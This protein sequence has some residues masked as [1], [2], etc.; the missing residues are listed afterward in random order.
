MPR[1]R[2][3]AWR[4]PMSAPAG[5]KPEQ[6]GRLVI[7]EAEAEECRIVCSAALLEA[8]RRECV[9]AARG[10]VPLGVGGALTGEYS[11]GTY[12]IRAWHPIPC[13]HQRGPSFLLTKEEV[14][15]LKE[16][17]SQL[18]AGAGKAEDI[19]VGW[20]VSHPHSGAVLRDDEISLHQRFFRASDLFLLIEIR[21]DGA[22]EIVVHRGARPVNPPWRILPAPS[23]RA[24]PSSAVR[25]GSAAVSTAPG[26][27][28]IPRGRPKRQSILR[29][30]LIPGLFLL[31]ASLSVPAWLYFDRRMPPPIDPANSQ[32]LPTFSLRVQRQG[33]GFLIRW[34]PLEPALA[35]AS[36][37]VLKI[38]DGNRTAER[39]LSPAEVRAGSLSYESASASLVIEL[40]AETSGGRAVRERVLFGQ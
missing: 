32:P 23:A 2:R 17:L 19:I 29:G 1:G 14:A 7:W 12:R 16:F 30:P 11:G 15:G 36:R 37:V 10:P 38:A 39:Q 6:P 33:R 24:E 4:S 5:S 13:R 22:L 40:R 27:A 8:I 25:A 20:F 31:A 3:E 34:N 18:P 26:H 21:P 28:P 35:G 9:L